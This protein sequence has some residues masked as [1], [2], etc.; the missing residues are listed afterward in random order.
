MARS[1]HALVRPVSAGIF[2]SAIFT[3]AAAAYGAADV[4]D[5]AK[6][7]AFTFADGEAIPAGSVISIDGCLIR[8]DVT[9][10]PSGQTSFALAMYSITPPSAQADNAAFAV[11]TT[12]L[13]YYLSQIALG[14][15]ANVGSALFITTQSIARVI[16]LT[17]NSL[18]GRYITA[19]AFT[20]AA[21]A[22][23]VQLFG[24]IL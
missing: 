9:A 11:T 1:D 18:F 24:R 14:T 16:K 8:N 12:D 21:V 5:V 23:Q 10:V 3:P 20:A 15:P 17:G 13:A 7:F 2:A 6:E 19:G 4:V 22:H